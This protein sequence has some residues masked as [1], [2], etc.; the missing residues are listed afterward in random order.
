[1]QQVWWSDGGGRV[2]CVLL[3]PSPLNHPPNTSLHPPILKV[4]KIDRSLK[5]FSQVSW[6]IRK[7]SFKFCLPK[8]RKN[9][10]YFHTRYGIDYSQNSFLQPKIYPFDLMQI[11]NQNF[12]IF[13][14]TF[15]GPE[16]LKNSIFPA[17]S[18]S[19]LK[20][21]SGSTFNEPIFD[22][23]NLT[24]LQ[25]TLKTHKNLIWRRDQKLCSL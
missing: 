1:M 4:H 10:S 13:Y 21:K 9:L 22:K 24:R 15:S 23:L 5:N 8:K 7:I 3:M 16:I 25:T 12:P 6:V 14:S 19:L 17:L 18:H 2:V 11:L 20:K